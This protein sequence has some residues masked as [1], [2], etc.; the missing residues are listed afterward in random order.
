[1]RQDLGVAIAP[2][3]MSLVNWSGHYGVRRVTT[4]IWFSSAAC[5]VA[6][7]RQAPLDDIGAGETGT[8][9]FRPSHPTAPFNRPFSRAFAPA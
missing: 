2:R 4:W 6:E 8:S 9:Q 7:L 3:L 1:M 5:P